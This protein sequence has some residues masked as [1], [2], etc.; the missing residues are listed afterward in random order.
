MNGR[1]SWVL[2]CLDAIEAEDFV[3]G[4]RLG[5]RVINGSIMV[6]VPRD[7]QILL[8]TKTKHIS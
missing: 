1:K 4:I 7:P 5:R 3:M 8:S 6:L 2:G